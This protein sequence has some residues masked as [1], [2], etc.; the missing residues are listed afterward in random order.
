M[1]SSAL[2]WPVAIVTASF[3]LMYGMVSAGASIGKGLEQ[4]GRNIDTKQDFS[5]FATLGRSIGEALPKTRA[6]MPSEIT[7]R[8]GPIPQAP[9]QPRPAWV[10][11]L[12]PSD[13]TTLAEHIKEEVVLW[14]QTE[15]PEFTWTVTSVS[16]MHVTDTGLLKAAYQY[17]CEE[18]DQIWDGGA[19]LRPNGF[20]GLIGT[21]TIHQV[22]KKIEIDSWPNT[23]P[24]QSR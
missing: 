20:Q 15:R 8:T 14:L 17:T 22:R 2:V 7:L 3:L 19:N 12:E 13:K 16:D 1:K 24:G 23:R 21:V 4:L 6:T 11:K 18:S 9:E 10:G 5:A